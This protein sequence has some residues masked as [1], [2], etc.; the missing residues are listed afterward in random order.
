MIK[1]YKKMSKLIDKELFNEL[2][3]FNYDDVD[4]LNYSSRG[5]RISESKFNSLSNKEKRRILRN[6][7]S[8][9]KSK[10]KQKKFIKSLEDEN[11]ILK[12]DNDLM[13]KQIK[14]LSSLLTKK[15]EKK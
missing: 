7:V 11:A 4:N 3:L 15:I 14:T 6:R 5:K 1:K 8:A 10:E 12:A 2:P 9:K 13:K